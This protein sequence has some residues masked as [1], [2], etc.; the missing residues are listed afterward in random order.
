MPSNSKNSIAAGIIALSLLAGGP[1]AAAAAASSNSGGTTAVTTGTAFF[2]DV[3]PGYWAEKSI[4]KLALQGIIV[5]EKGMF[6]P[7][8]ERQPAGS[9][10]HGSALYG[11]GESDR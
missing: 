8:A 1:A 9:C 6:R 11:Q 3:K 2:A 4:V 7:A 5:G 10:R